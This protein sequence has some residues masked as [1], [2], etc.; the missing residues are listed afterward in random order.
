MESAEELVRRRTYIAD[1]LSRATR[2]RLVIAGFGL[3]L[4]LC[5]VAILAPLVAPYDP[6]AFEGT[7]RLLP[8]SRG[9]PFGTDH[10]GRD[11]LS[12]VIFG[13]RISLFVGITS[14]S[15]G[16]TFGSVLGLI[17][18]FFGGRLD[19]ALCR[20]LDIFFGV[21]TLLLA[22]ALSAVL[23]TGVLN[24][25]IAI[26]VINT[27]FFARM[28]RGPALVEKGK[29][30]FTAAIM[31]GVGTSRIL[32]KHL[33]PNVL[34]CI[35]V[36]ASLS[37]SFAILTEASL[38]FVGLGIQPPTPSWGNMLNEGRTFLELA[39]WTSIFPGLAIALAVLA[40]NLVGD[41]LRDALDPTMRGVL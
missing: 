2:N 14:V 5:M 38:G 34:S 12:R 17:G 31:V 26:S 3:A 24:P 36:Q 1:I 16:A 9:H 19:D 25:I 33:L 22:I 28:V 7:D 37:T 35:I 10:L 29:E 13:T 15:V 18:A 27:P 21:P 23:G 40:F 41:G 39:P 20:I 11:V 8:P 6:T 30:Y 4:L 32:V